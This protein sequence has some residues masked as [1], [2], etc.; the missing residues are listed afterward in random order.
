MKTQALA[1]GLDSV[2]HRE[3]VQQKMYRQKSTSTNLLR[4]FKKSSDLIEVQT[5]YSNF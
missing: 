1:I 3:D 4:S 2:F 5:K